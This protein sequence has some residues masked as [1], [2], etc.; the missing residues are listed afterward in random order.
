[1]TSRHQTAAHG[2]AVAGLAGVFAYQGVVP[3]LWKR[4]P[5]EVAIWQGLGLPERRATRMVLV[6]GA[7]EAT[8]AVV[9]VARRNHRWPF[10]V[11]LAAMPAVALVA[12]RSDRSLVTRTFNP[13]SF[14][15]AVVA[16]AG[17]ALATTRE[18]S[19]SRSR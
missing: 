1:M 8:F 19:P 16:L 5:G 6:T 7:A 11:P 10:L 9:T 17:V 15:V 18:A 13:V 2:I 12:S 14:A 4:D 3:K